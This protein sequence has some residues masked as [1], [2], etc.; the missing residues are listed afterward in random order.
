MMSIDEQQ[1]R[2]I[3]FIA[4][5]CRPSGAK[6][7]DEPGIVANLRKLAHVNLAEVTMATIRAASNR[8]A[9]NP[10][11][12]PVMTGEHWRE[13]VSDSPRP[14]PPRR[15]EECHAHP[16]QRATNCGGCRADH[17]RGDESPGRPITGDT[18]AG[19]AAVRAAL[20][21]RKETS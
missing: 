11:V 15:D 8:Q 17:Q 4:A 1:M 3:A 9:E 12:I 13:K 16:G 2:A 19:I 6:A 10:G 7:W 21:A 5:R 18:T 14:H 20:N